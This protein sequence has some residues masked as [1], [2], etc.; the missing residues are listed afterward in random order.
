MNLEHTTSF[1]PGVEGLRCLGM[2]GK[3]SD[4]GVGQAGMDGSPVGSTIGALEHTTSF[5][6]GVEGLRC[7]GM[8]GC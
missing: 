6:P 4:N 8:D 2:D 7:L 1:S 3:G 5:S